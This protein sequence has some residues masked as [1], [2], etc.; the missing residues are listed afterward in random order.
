MPITV[1]ENLGSQSSDDEENRSPLEAKNVYYPNNIGYSI[2]CS[3]N[4]Y[5][6]VI[7]G[8][9]N[10][11]REALTAILKIFEEQKVR[12][13]K[14]S[15]FN[16]QSPTQFVMDMI[17]DFSNAKCTPADLALRLN[18]LK[19][20][21][22]LGEYKGS[23]RTIFPEFLFPLTFFGTVRA[24]AIDSDR[25]TRLFSHI[26]EALGA[27]RAKRLL[28]ED[29]RS[30]GTE[31]VD[32]IKELL[33]NVDSNNGK[34]KEL[35]DLG[36]ESVEEEKT[37]EDTVF[38]NARAFVRAA[39]WGT[40]SYS[41]TEGSSSYLV[42]LWDPPTD[43]D[44]GIVTGNYFLQ[45]MIAG[46]IESLTGDSSKLNLRIMKE[47]YD[48]ES[49]ALTLYYLNK[50]IQEEEMQR[51]EE[52]IAEIEPPK[53]E[54]IDEKEP[55][56]PVIQIPIVSQTAS[57]LQIQSQQLPPPVEESKVATNSP[58]PSV[59]E[60]D[61]G[62]AEAQ[63]QVNRLIK[64]IGKIPKVYSPAAC[65][66]EIIP[67]ESPEPIPRKEEIVKTVENTSK[68]RGEERGTAQ[69]E[70]LQKTTTNRRGR[71]NG[72]RAVSAKKTEKTATRNI[73]SKSTESED[74]FWL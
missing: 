18:K 60:N 71:K 37:A 11:E 42:T 16:D 74:N 28:Y 17:T 67:V 22:K 73:S 9:Q 51:N 63:E 35:R 15:F 25:F 12:I 57:G 72:F 70:V 48:S 20:F 14:L 45:G 43:A 36:S 40:F 56:N 46:I 44:G 39:G 65:E 2:P 58:E 41:K 26:S 55:A 50:V 7:M 29:G 24:L 54:P 52:G 27:G 62:S 33:E 1:E 23:N 31:I 32:T 13:S 3:K 38:Q 53:S 21:V 30:E 4:Q 68:N 59:E 69:E 10:K 49:R 47:S 64:S 8:L 34:R 6:F 66:K 61:D 5:E 19:K